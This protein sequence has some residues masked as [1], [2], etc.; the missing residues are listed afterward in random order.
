MERRTKLALLIL[1]G[2]LLLLLGLYLLL[3]PF[4]PARQTAQP[5]ALPGSV[6]PYSLGGV[7]K[8]TKG[9]GGASPI[10]TGTAAVTPESN[11]QLVIENNARTIVERVGSGTSGN[12]FLGYQDAL[13]S[14]TASGQTTLLAE[15]QRMQQIYPAKGPAFG[16]STH[17]VS[18]HLTDGHSGDAR[19][20]V[21]VQAV[22][23]QDSGVPSLPQK[24][25]GKQI[26]VSFV[27][28]SDGRYLVDS[29]VW[30]DI[31]L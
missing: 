8:G 25:L 3:S 9:Q 21:T 7:N 27:K 13:L 31:E 20:S 18:S 10:A 17:A 5:P 11:S 19:L 1:V 6:Q 4:L 30:S 22:Q 2:L 28:Q 23:T 12:G 24:T 15:Q 16:I 14:M 26:I 29:L